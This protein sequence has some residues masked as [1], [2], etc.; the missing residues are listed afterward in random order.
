MLIAS[1]SHIVLVMSC[2]AAAFATCPLHSHLANV[3][4]C[5]ADVLDTALLGAELA[6]KALNASNIVW[7]ASVRLCLTDPAIHTV[8]DEIAV[9]SGGAAAI[10]ME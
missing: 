7:R 5:L 4:C 1:I 10:L 9:R 2:F 3:T 8:D 6:N